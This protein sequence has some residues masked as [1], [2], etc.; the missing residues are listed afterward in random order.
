MQLPFFS[1]SA[2]LCPH[3]EEVPDLGNLTVTAVHWDGL[4]LD[5][6]APDGICE[7]FIIEIQEADQAKGAHSLTVPGSLR[8]VDIPGLRAGT[9][10]TAT[11]HGQ[12]RGRSTP[13]LVVEAVTG[14]G[15]SFHTRDVT[16]P[17]SLWNREHSPC[18]RVLFNIPDRQCERKFE[19]REVWVGIPLS[20]LDVL[21]S[22]V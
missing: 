18:I 22:V 3:A 6:T 7:Q 1:N 15:P 14:I 20:W 4:S 11:L 10:Y 12:V 17:T 8:S 21:G 16:E 9:P 19:L 5:W 13:P 2:T